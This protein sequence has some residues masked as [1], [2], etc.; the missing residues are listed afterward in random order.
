MPETQQ[1]LSREV[2]SWKESFDPVSLDSFGIE[3]QDRWR[4]LHPEAF[5]CTRLLLDMDTDRH[6]GRRDDAFWGKIWR[7]RPRRYGLAP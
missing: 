2:L 4:P 3:Q 6:E 5:H 1:K 7:R